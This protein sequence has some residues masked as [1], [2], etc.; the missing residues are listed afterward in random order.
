MV[1]YS[2]TVGA[3]HDTEHEHR[4]DDEGPPRL[5]IVCGTCGSHRLR[6]SHPRNH[7]ERVARALTPLRYHRCSDCGERGYHFS[8]ATEPSV[9]PRHL[10]RPAPPAGRRQELRDALAT[11]AQRRRILISV[12]IAV[13]LG[14]LA[15][16]LAA[17]NG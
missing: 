13:F 10:V 5:G 3:T 11:R 14:A 4:N 9:R 8:W 7:L 1:V 17:S 6:R 12:T 16:L 2:G 15:A